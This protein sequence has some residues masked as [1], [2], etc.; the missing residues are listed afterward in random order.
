M[1]YT[2]YITSGNQTPNFLAIVD[3]L[4]QPFLDLQGLNVDLDINTATGTM[5]DIIGEWVGVPRQ[6]SAPLDI[7]LLWD[8][9]GRTWDSSYIWGDETASNSG[10]VTLDDTSYRFV[11]KFQILRN[12]YDGTKAT[13]YEIISTLSTGTAIILEDAMNM[14]INV[15]VALASLDTITQALLTSGYL[16]FAPFGVKTNYY[17]TPSHDGLMF[18]W[19]RSSTAFGGWDTSYWATIH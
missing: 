11:I 16:N 17:I 8:T 10:I 15:I 2:S 4:T 19:D 7:A 14:T 3:K 13:A 5:L 18:A 9:V 1:S 6:L 12:R